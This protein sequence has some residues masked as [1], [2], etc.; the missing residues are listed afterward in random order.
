MPALPVRRTLVTG[1]RSMFRM[2]RRTDGMPDVPGYCPVWD[3]QPVATETMRLRG[4]QTSY[5][6]D[7]PIIDG[8]RFPDV[9]R[10]GGTPPAILR[11]RPRPRSPRSSASRRPPSTFRAGIAE[12]RELERGDPTSSRSTRSIPWTPPR[13]RRST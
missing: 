2:W 12:L 4:V 6:T 3:W 11:E 7:N 5:V 8:P 10:P 9:V 1:M 13:R